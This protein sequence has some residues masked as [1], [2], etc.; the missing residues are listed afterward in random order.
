[1]TVPTTG[2]NVK[3]FKKK[4]VIVKVWDIGG[5]LLFRLEWNLYA[6]GADSILFVIDAA[7]V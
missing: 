4:G 7:D 2:L 1:M 6:R 3:Q 5:Q